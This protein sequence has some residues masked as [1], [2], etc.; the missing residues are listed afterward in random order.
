MAEGITF[1]EMDE[2]TVS[3]IVKR[4]DIGQ[5]VNLQTSAKNNIVSAINE[6]FINVSDGKNA[7]AA[8]I[9]GKGVPASGSDNFTVLAT[10]IQQLGLKVVSGSFT[11][12]ENGLKTINNL[13]FR[14]RMIIATFSIQF[15]FAINDTAQNLNTTS[16]LSTG[17]VYATDD[18]TST[19]SV[20][21]MNGNGNTSIMPKKYVTMKNVVFGSNYV[22]ME[23]V[24]ASNWYNY[25]V[26]G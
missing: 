13:S 25:L 18:N 17:A 16:I 20:L 5:L 11:N 1:Q 10:K 21:L 8:A 2:E 15:P 7:I 19:T 3:E 23:L 14:P 6:L 4:N 24:D 22:T 26:M 9:T 12:S